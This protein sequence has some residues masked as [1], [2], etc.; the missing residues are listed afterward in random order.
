MDIP[1]DH[2][3]VIACHCRPCR[4]PKGY[5]PKYDNEGDSLLD[6]VQDT[7]GQDA[8]R[9]LSDDTHFV[10]VSCPDASMQRNKWSDV[11]DGT[12][13]IVYGMACPVYPA[14]DGGL[15]VNPSMSIETLKDILDN[16]YPKLKPGG[17]VIF[18]A[19]YS[20]LN[21][22]DKYNPDPR[23]RAN[24]SEHFLFRVMRSNSRPKPNSGFVIFTKVAP[25]GGRQRSRK[26]R[27]RV[28]R[29]AK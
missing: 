16:S 21:T 4:R 10:D 19:F 24:L 1:P 26:T 14:L 23:W 8:I 5:V 2:E 11:P 9:T 22:L 6:I 27:R 29:A 25:A 18:P 15:Q 12:I 7:V 3:I 20:V 28:K 17:I 13:R